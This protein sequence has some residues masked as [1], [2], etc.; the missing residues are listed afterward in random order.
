MG[1]SLAGTIETNKARLAAA[2]EPRF[3]VVTAAPQSKRRPASA[4]NLGKRLRTVR[5]A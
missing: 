4:G 5:L 1:C 2:V 3:N